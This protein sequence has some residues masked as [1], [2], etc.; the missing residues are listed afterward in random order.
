MSALPFIDDLKTNL[1]TDQILTEPEDLNVYSFDGT[2]T[3]HQLPVC[4]VM[5]ENTDQ[6]VHT[7]KTAHKHQ[8][9]VVTR[10]SGTGL[11]G[12]AVPTP[13]C[14]V[15]CVARMN[16]ILEIDTR[17]LTL[18]TE[19]GVITQNIFD[20]ATS[21]GLFYPP[22]PGSMKISTIGG[23]VANNS[24]GLRGLK[25]GVTRDYVMALEVVLS[26]GR[27]LKT[28][29]KCVKDVAGFTLKDLFIGSEGT[30]GVITQITLK[31]IPQPKT[32]KTMLAL[33]DSMEDAAETISA[34]I[35]N[36]I[37]PCTLEFLDS[38]TAKCVEDYAHVGLP[39]N[40]GAVLLMEVDGHPAEV[41]E[42]TEQIMTIAKEHNATDIRLA[43]DNAEA[44]QLATAR[45]SALSAL[46]QLAPTI[47]LEDVTV[48]RSELAKMVAYVQETAERHN[49]K[50]GTFG[51]M[52]DG[53]LHPTFLT[54]ERKPE[55]IHRVE[56]ALKDVAEYAVKLGGTITGEHGV[57]LA[58]KS[59]L[60]DA[61]GPVAMDI[62]RQV[63][64]S[65]D[66]LGILNP[67]KIFD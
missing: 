39:T 64:K 46:A 38:T 31:L 49:V 65:F 48:P 35:R 17:N 8:I 24:G 29:T 42:Q 40:V 52:G 45:R 32:K 54:D 26:D 12:G 1:K 4:V 56:L 66:P 51:H 23:N 10:G 44:L 22:D 3:L 18:T 58:K 61:L 36:K 50:V 15:L 6:V 30:L 28:G 20:A 2:A 63:K 14:I 53:N 5:A 11:S 25:Y 9:P 41:D 37:V 55:E 43:T 16:N 47:F 60:P 57:G 19:P 7:L 67:G 34:I 62:L 21:E 33:Y 27:I 59:F 13:G